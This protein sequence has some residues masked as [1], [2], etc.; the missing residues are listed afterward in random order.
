MELHMTVLRVLPLT[1]KSKSMYSTMK[2]DAA[3]SPTLMCFVKLM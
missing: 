1:L 2:G 3:I